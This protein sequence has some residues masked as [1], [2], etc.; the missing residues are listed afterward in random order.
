MRPLRG[1]MS[2]LGVKPIDCFEP[3]TISPFEELCR[4]MS[5]VIF[6]NRMGPPSRQKLIG[7]GSAMCSNF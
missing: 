4:S 3:S 5:L 6:P 1:S 7:G 2:K